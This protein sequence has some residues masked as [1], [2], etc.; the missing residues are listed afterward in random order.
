MN[1][2]SPSSQSSKTMLL[3]ET[4]SV[5]SLPEDNM[6]QEHSNIVSERFVDDEVLG[7]CICGELITFSNMRG[8]SCSVVICSSC[9]E[10]MHLRCALYNSI[11]DI[12]KTEASQIIRYRKT[13]S[14][15][16]IDCIVCDESRCPCCVA[17]NP[18]KIKSRA[19][20]IITPPAIL[21]QWKREIERHTRMPHNDHK[22]LKVTIYDGMQHLIKDKNTKSM[23]AFQ[24]ADA[25]VVLMTFECLMTDL[26]HSDDNRY[27]GT[28][29][30]ST[31]YLRN[32]KMYRVVPS[33]LT[34]IRWWRICL[35]EAQRVE[36]PTSGAAL[37]AR[38]LESE[39]LWY[40]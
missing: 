6:I 23:H 22:P 37:M 20:L 4:N 39:Y 19:T 14:D 29:I 11:D 30:S 3:V 7:S 17:C 8:H 13:F 33:P 27:V 16:T 26:S 24:L 25:D 15:A 9:D 38:K 36:T 1:S 10:P 35:D 2:N 12:S 28:G 18:V 32:R 5:E 21:T 34:S 40:V 31:K